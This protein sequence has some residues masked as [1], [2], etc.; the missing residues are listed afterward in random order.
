[1]RKAYVI[2]DIVQDLLVQQL[3]V[4][5]CMMVTA[6]TRKETEF[7]LSLVMHLSFVCL[8]VLRLN[9]PV[10][11]FSVMSGRSQRFLGLTSTVGS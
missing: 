9:I 5:K 6:F 3:C 7:L 11:N 1:M 2:F 4:I 10:N 8:F